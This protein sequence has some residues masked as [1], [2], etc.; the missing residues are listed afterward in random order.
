LTNRQDKAPKILVG[1]AMVSYRPRVDSSPFDPIG[2][3]TGFSEISMA[4]SRENPGEHL[5]LFLATNGLLANFYD[6]LVKIGLGRFGI[7]SIINP[8]VKG[9]KNPLY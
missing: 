3:F 4:N 2:K 8:L 1:I 9:V 7:P 6:L 5:R